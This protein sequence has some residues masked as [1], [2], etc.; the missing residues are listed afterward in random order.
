MNP[1]A[2]APSREALARAGGADDTGSVGGTGTAGGARGAAPRAWIVREARAVA[3]ICLKDLRIEWRNLDNLPAMFFFALLVIVIFSFGF[4]FAA[5]TFAQLGPGLLWVTF[6]FAGV[7]A[8]GQSF[9]LERQADGLSGM[10][11]APIDPGSLYLGKLL[12]NLVTMLIV[13]AL[14]LPLC[15]VLFSARIDA[16]FWPLGLAILVHT[17]GF[18]AVGTLFGAMTAR[19]RRGDVLLPILLFGISIPLMISAVKTTAAVFSD[20]PALR[21]AAGAWLTMASIFDVVFLTAA[22]VTF[23]YVI[24]E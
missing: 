23:E 13:E 18:A 9:A 22:Y 5:F 12:A 4:D 15:G 24:E 20:D 1:T 17:I 19:T 21:Q 14:V 8:F 10:M 2:D 6:A 16:V 7:L 11:L 3:L